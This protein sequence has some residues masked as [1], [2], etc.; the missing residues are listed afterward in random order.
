MVADTPHATLYLNEKLRIPTLLHEAFTAA[1][2]VY[3]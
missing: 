2:G 1:Y 3:P